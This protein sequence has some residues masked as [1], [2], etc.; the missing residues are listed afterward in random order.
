MIYDYCLREDLEE[1]LDTWRVVFERYGLKISRTK[2]EYLP[3]PTYDS[4][5]TG[6]SVT[7][8]VWPLIEARTQPHI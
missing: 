2:T 4:E 3:I 6:K 7:E 8:V 1:Y 5:T